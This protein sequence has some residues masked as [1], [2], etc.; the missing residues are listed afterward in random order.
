MS[1]DVDEPVHLEEWSPAWQTA[2]DVL[3]AECREALGR[4]ALAVEHVGSTAVPGL[5]AKPIID[6]L[7]GVAAGRAT[8]VAARLA[9]RGWTHLGEAGVPG[10]EYL[11]RR[12]GQHANL[13]VVEHGSALWQDDLHLRDHL[14]RD[15]DARRRYAAAKRE[16]VREAPSL[17]AYSARKSAVVAELLHE[18]RR[19]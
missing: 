14:R 17:L 16:A 9:T 2:A 12:S 1:A 7:I 13:H 15:A 3:V 4:E 5:A 18:A 11:R 10:R 19:G 8:A 6:V